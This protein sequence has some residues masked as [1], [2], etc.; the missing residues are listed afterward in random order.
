MMMIKEKVMRVLA[1]TK[2]LI[3]IE[4]RRSQQQGVGGS[5]VATILG[6]IIKED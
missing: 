4:C 1:K 5:D 3:N 2:G 6:E